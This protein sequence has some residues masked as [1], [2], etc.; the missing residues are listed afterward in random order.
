MLISNNKRYLSGGHVAIL[1]GIGSMIP[2]AVNADT[3]KVIVQDQNENSIPKAKIQIGN[4]EQTT[5]DSGTVTF[6]D[7]PYNEFLIVTALGFSSKRL[8]IT[9]G[10]NRSDSETRSDPNY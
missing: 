3:L 9:T 2:M 8:N 5:D 1:L 6:S 10:Q 4:Q 7:V